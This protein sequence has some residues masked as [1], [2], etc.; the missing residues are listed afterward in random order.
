MKAI[1]GKKK[2]NGKIIRVIK[3]L[4]DRKCLECD[5]VFT[6]KRSDSK[7]CSRKCGNKAERKR[8]RKANAERS[9]KWYA[10]NRTKELERR[11]KYRQDNIEKIRK[12]N[13]EW[14]KRNRDKVRTKDQKYKDKTQTLFEACEILEISR[15]AL[16]DKRK[17]FDL[18]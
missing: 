7:Y 11:R 13:R 8:S 16:Y 5:E 12:Q 18:I 10:K 9:R 6:P 1:Y 15:S 2:V 4:D 14:A 17:K 3:I